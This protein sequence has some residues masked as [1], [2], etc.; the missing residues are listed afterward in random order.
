MADSSQEPERGD[1]PG[2]L[3]AGNATPV[4][5]SMTLLV[6]VTAVMATLIVLSELLM[7]DV[8]LAWA[9]HGTFHM[10][11]QAEYAIAA[12]GGAGCLWLT[13]LFFRA[14]MQYERSA[15]RGE[16]GAGM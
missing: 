13:Y 9:L 15:A 3:L 11:N 5:R 2:P 16:P 4:I 12:L 1:A 14:A 6:C 10:G 7:I 8:S